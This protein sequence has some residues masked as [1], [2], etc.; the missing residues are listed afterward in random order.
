MSGA[1]RVRGATAMQGDDHR[2][3]SVGRMTALDETPRAV[4]LGAVRRGARGP[5][6]RPGDAAPD[7]PASDDRPTGLADLLVRLFAVTRSVA[8]QRLEA[9]VYVAYLPG[10]HGRSGQPMRLVGGDHVSYDDRVTR[11][12]EAAIR[13]HDD[14]ARVLLVGHAQGGPA[15]LDIAAM[16]ESSLFEVDRV[17][18]AGA[19]SALVPR[20]PRATRMLSL[21]DRSDPAALLGSLV[22]AASPNRLTVVFDGDGAETA[23]ERYIAGARL[24]DTSPHPD[25]VHAITDLRELGYLA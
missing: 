19:P 21:E 14:H 17:V 20:V 10:P 9:G 1:R 25:L 22:N 11:A 3:A 13:R 4:D 5:A 12:L 8:V 24:A 15:A 7:E 16:A 18:T 6:A 2:V 23:A